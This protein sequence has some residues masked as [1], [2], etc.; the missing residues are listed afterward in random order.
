[1]FEHHRPIRPAARRWVTASVT[2]SLL[3]SLSCTARAASDPQVWNPLDTTPPGTPA[4]IKLDPQMPSTHTDT[5]I[6]VIIRR[7]QNF[8][9]Q[10][11]ILEATGQTF[12]DLETGGR[13]AKP[14]AASKTKANNIK[15][16]SSKKQ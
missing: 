2:L 5:Y 12:E 7:W 1:M 13:V 9:G 11:A 14:E 16:P 10:K 15:K 8:T 4:E 3:A 6:D